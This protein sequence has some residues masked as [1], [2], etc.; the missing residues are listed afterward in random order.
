MICDDYVSFSNRKRDLILRQ[1]PIN[2]VM[3]LHQNLA[4]K[5]Q[6]VGGLS[7]FHGLLCCFGCLERC[8]CEILSNG[9]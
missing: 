3:K 6:N 9:E 7:R 8:E 5:Q 1:R 4:L 2:L